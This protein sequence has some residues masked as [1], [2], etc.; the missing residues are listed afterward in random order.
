M[1]YYTKIDTKSMSSANKALASQLE[2]I[3][4]QLNEE[5]LASLPADEILEMRKKLNPYG[6]TIEGS[7][8]YLNF[9]ITQI[10]HDYWKKFITSAM[11]AF[12]NR[13]ND[14]WK[15]PEGVPVT[16]VYE[17]L[18]DPTKVDTPKAVVEKA[19][20]PTIDSYEFNREWMKKR[21]IV[22]EF[23]EEEVRLLDIR[24]NQG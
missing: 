13:M 7:D 22:K 14:E 11:V 4:G 23:L 8:K 19:Y 3:L 15:V 20:K 2:S 21:I 1:L 5:D 6:R 18:E 12:L 9:S 17:Y 10:H 16:P 24:G